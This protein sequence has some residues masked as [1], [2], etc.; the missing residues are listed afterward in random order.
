MSRRLSVRNGGFLW[1]RGASRIRRILALAGYEVSIGAPE[2]DGL[3]GVWG[4]SPTSHRGEE[5]A[6]N[7]GATLVRIE[8]AFLRSLHP[9][10]TGEPPLGLVIDHSGVHFDGRSPSDLETLLLSHPLDDSALMARAR[11]GIARMREA[12]LS[13]YSATEMAAA[14]PEPGYVLI[15]DQTRGDASVT[16]SGGDRSRFLEMLTA[17][18]LEH[19]GARF[20]IKTHPETTAGF[21]EGHYQS[22]DAQDK[23]QIYD[24]NASAWTLLE[25]ATAVYTLSSQMGFEAI[26]AGHKPR[27]FGMPFYAGWGLTEDEDPI[28]RRTRTLSRAQLFAG[29]MILFPKWY[30]PY[31]DDLCEIEDVLATLEARARA[32]RQDNAGWIASGMRLWKRRPIQK[33]FASDKGMRFED[34]VDKA[35]EQASNTGR[36]HLSWAGKTNRPDVARVEDGFLR[37]RGLGAELIP[38]LSLVLDSS[39]IYY[40]PATP[41]DL[42]RAISARASEFRPDQYERISRLLASIRASNLTKYNLSGELPT[43]PD[44]PLLLVPG[45]VEDDAS[46][47]L[48]CP[49]TNTNADLLKRARAD[50]PNAFIVF[51]PHPDVEAGLRNGKV[52]NPEN[53]ADV[54]LEN[55]PIAAVLDLVSEVWTMTSLT[56]FEAL[57]RGC[58]VTTL[59]VP[60]YAGWGLTH[61][62]AP[63]PA[64]RLEG[65]RPSL[66]SLA[67]ATLI[68]YPRYYD[69]ITGSACPPEVV[70]DRLANNQVPKP[71]PFNR[72]LAKLQGALASKSYLWR[73]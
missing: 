2:A 1:S 18:R 71:G 14:A 72:T 7:S 31:R 64:R 9:G 45:Q 68:D 42:E 10:R 56:G 34:D 38:P 22:D 17:A 54:T 29:A 24:G 67:Y 28:H 33:F 41:S 4:A 23:I 16:A 8:D 46:I 26:L 49:E 70:V 37:S 13:K 65:A 69:P 12:Q 44:G 40:D 51:K 6:K 27:V 21:R 30:D 25:G 60:F 43:L 47:K 55:A 59:G 63:I 58:K 53:W 36:N 20:V 15:V 32:W 61:D 35:A 5:L 66:E 48:G 50:N 73:H 11:G 39:G 52:E 62:F 57:L 3:V 19:P